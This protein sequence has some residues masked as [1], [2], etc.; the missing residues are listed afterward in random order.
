[1]ALRNPQQTRERLLKSAFEEIHAHGFQGMRVD[2]VLRRS[3]LQKGAF[4]HHFNSK[5]ELGYAVLEEQIR[6][7]VEYV[8]L[9]PL[10]EIDDPVRDFPLLL[11]GLGERMPPE[12]L[13]HGC[14]VNNLAQEMASQDEGF[15]QR[16]TQ[17]FERW[18]NGFE[19]MFE[20]GKAGGY[21]REDVDSR[22]VARFM[23]AALE[24]CIGV[25][26]VERSPEQWAACRSEIQTYLETLRP[27]SN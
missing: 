7:M 16:I 4:Y 24:G 3:G 26:K 22:A 5:A 1:M 12:M 18:I 17:I 13:E 15:R 11:N 21:I 20:R 10:A 23:I 27:G 14:P 19:A 2:E 9:E 6:P 25:Y 8:W